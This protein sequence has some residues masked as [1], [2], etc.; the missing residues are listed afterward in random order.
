MRTYLLISLAIL[1]AG[2]GAYT[3]RTR[4]LRRCGEAKF[5]AAQ[6][7]E[8]A[9]WLRSARRDPFLAPIFRQAA[10]ADFFTTARARAGAIAD[11]LIFEDGFDP[12][13]PAPGRAIAVRPAR[14]LG[15]R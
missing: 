13:A 8:P 5:L 3:A 15:A 12:A 14:L 6:I 4:S 7:A 2:A 10:L 9:G 11:D 1:L